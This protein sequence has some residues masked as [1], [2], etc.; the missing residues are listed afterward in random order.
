MIAPAP[1]PTR[2]RGGLYPT[3]RAM[4][5]VLAPALAS[6]ATVIWPRLLPLVL[7]LD[8]VVVL[9]LA[10]DALLGLPLRRAFACR[11]ELPRLWSVRRPERI[12][13]QIDHHG[14]RSLRGR[15]QLDLPRAF[16]SQDAGR[17]LDLPPRQRVE[18]EAH[19]TPDQRGAF[20]LDGLH[21][22]LPSRLGLW[23]RHLH[24]SD[25]QSVHVYPD[26]RQLS[27]YAL[28]ARRDRLSLIG[29][30]RQ[31]RGGGDTDFERLRDHQSGD[32]LQ[33]IDWK[34]TARRDHL[35]V[36]DYQISRSQRLMLLIDA[37]R[38]ML[39]RSLDEQGSDAGSLLDRAI[40]SALMLAWVAL[41]QGD[42]VGLIAYADGV[43]RFIPA[44]GGPRQLNRIIHALHDLQPRLVE[45]RHDLALLELQ[46][47]ERKRCLSVLFTH[48]LD[49]VNAEML[50]RHLTVLGGRH[51]P[52][53]VLLRD[54]ELHAPLQTQPTDVDGFWRTGAAAGIAA[55]RAQVL[56]DL[57]AAGALTIDTDASGLTPELVNNYLTVKARH[58]L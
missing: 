9:L 54:R 15:M 49:E 11:L 16:A 46:R 44:E 57:R 27:D 19:A 34:A 5:L 32:P 21:L 48:V 58:L 55:W 30:Q 37:G 3:W 43:L 31:R 53:A 47:H 29:V 12:R 2:P 7:I 28:L 42:R 1:L 38:M 45:S 23:Q 41:H 13:V 56:K 10:A 52:L 26:L 6:A 35:T 8:A 50:R 36:R 18:L 14:R 25:P 22:A 51:L 17:D 40:D 20:V 24:L 4:L 33:R 39:S